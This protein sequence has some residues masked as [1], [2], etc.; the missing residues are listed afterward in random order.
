M[1]DRVHS[2]T[3]VLDRD[4]RIDDIQPL[5]DTLHMFRN[6]IKVEPNVTDI[7]EMYA[8]EV[9]IKTELRQKIF[10]LVK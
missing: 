4:I 2:L 10:D 7:S 8:A 3:V 5:I 1:T 9:R 6:V